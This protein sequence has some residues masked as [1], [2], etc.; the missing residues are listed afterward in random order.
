MS[1]EV[2]KAVKEGDAVLEKRTIDIPKGVEVILLGK[3]HIRVKAK[4]TTLERKFERITTQ[5]TIDEK[6]NK[7]EIFDFF[8]KRHTRALV[9]TIAAHI[10]NMIKGVQKPFVYKLKIIYSHFPI[11]VK[12]VGNEVEYTG[13]Y[14]QRDRKRVPILGA[15][16]KVKVSG[17]DI[18]VSGP[19]LEAVSQTAASIEQSTRL[20]GKRSKDNRIFQD[21]I[22]VYERNR[23]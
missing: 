11:T 22:Y 18:E 2:L 13:L 1:N 5:I 3:N 8:V 20:R 9:G 17:E 12:V 6:E 7:I 23:N 21:G 4:K 19:D 14:G 10:V 16:T 15:D